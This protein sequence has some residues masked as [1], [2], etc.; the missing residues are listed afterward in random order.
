MCDD[1]FMV[2]PIEIHRK[3]TLGKFP[4]NT[5]RYYLEP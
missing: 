2:K 5:T 3:G 1:I 4:R